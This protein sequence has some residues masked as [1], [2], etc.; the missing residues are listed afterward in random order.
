MAPRKA[1]AVTPVDL[2]KDDIWDE[3]VSANVVPPLK[4]KGVVL[5]QPTQRRV[6]EWKQ[7]GNDA[8][9]GERALFGDQYEAIKAVFADEPEYVWENFNIKYLQHMF[10]IGTEAELGK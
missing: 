5:T 6:E 3:L 8:D 9:A 7:V 4:V 1:V 10:G 2:D